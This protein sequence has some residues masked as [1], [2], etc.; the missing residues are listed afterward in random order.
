MV[1]KPTWSQVVCCV[2]LL[3]HPFNHNVG[4]W[5]CPIPL[6]NRDVIGQGGHCLF[7]LSKLAL[8]EETA[9]C[10]PPKTPVERDA[11]EAYELCYLHVLKIDCKVYTLQAHKQYHKLRHVPQARL[12]TT[13]NCD[14]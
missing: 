13:F 2:V 6:P 5:D 1:L 11:N 3:R 12:T 14:K 9:P 10:A 7:D 8:K 4:L